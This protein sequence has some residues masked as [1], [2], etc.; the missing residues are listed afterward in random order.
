MLLTVSNKNLSIVMVKVYPIQY[1]TPLPAALCHGEAIRL[2]LNWL[3]NPSS[4]HILPHS[5]GYS[6]QKSKKT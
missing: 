2:M 4:V 6:P 5:Y 1:E 3:Q